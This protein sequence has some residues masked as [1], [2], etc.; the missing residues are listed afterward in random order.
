[1]IAACNDKTLRKIDLVVDENSEPGKSLKKKI[2][3][4][5]AGTIKDSKRSL[6][7]AKIDRKK[8]NIFILF[9]LK[10]Y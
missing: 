2:V 1:L 4:T 6:I 10:F 5:F 3:G 7:V 9:K 8:Y